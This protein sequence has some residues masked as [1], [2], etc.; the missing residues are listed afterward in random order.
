M[1]PAAI[2]VVDEKR[3]D[4]DES[5]DDI[6]KRGKASRGTRRPGAEPGC[7]MEREDLFEPLADGQ[8][9]EIVDGREHDRRTE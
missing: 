5:R 2:V 6:A 7:A 9:A 4:L 1:A 3:Y 8:T